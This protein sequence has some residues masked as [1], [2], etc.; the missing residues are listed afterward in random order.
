MQTERTTKVLLGIIV[1]LDLWSPQ[2]GMALQE[3]SSVCSG[4]SP[5]GCRVQAEA[6]DAFA[7]FNLGTMYELGEGVV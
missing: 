5:E 1:F 6:G 4:S 3:G 2:A 7:Q